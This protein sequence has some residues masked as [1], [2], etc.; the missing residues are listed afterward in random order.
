MVV[1]IY[2]A[3]ELILSLEVFICKLVDSLLGSGMK[4][5]GLLTW[6]SHGCEAREVPQ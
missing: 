4:Q 5:V 3:S 2:C 6:A 1:G